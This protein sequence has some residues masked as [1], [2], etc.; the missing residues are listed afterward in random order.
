MIR[1]VKKEISSANI[2]NVTVEHNGFQ[3]GDT[4]HGGFV[5]ITLEDH[6]STDMRCKVKSDVEECDYQDVESIELFFGG[7]TERDTLT[8]ALEIILTE[9]KNNE[10]LGDSNRVITVD[11]TEKWERQ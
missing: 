6:G 1:K 10:N 2:L 11:L 9:L 4:G 7:D 8:E 3:G 5:K